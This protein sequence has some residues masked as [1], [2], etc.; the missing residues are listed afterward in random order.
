MLFV[1]GGST[2]KKFLIANFGTV[3][4]VKILSPFLSLFI[5]WSAKFKLF[6]TIKVIAEKIP[7][8]SNPFCETVSPK[9]V[10]PVKAIIVIGSKSEIFSLRAILSSPKFYIF[11]K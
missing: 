6:V 9:N 2:G 8:Y 7:L 1:R 3:K 11:W 10:S 4:T 5:A